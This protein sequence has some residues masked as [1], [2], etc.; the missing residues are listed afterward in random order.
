MTVILK[1]CDFI[2]AVAFLRRVFTEILLP[3]FCFIVVTKS[4]FPKLKSNVHSL[5]HI[6]HEF[7]LPPS[8]NDCKS[9]T[10]C[11][12]STHLDRYTINKNSVFCC[13][14]MEK[15]PNHRI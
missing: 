14:K 9:Q 8:N 13:E 15:N 11:F 5:E 10:A 12:D 7:L 1:A 3:L 4:F 2:S 6:C